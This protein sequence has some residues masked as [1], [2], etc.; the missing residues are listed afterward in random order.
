MS[1]F[2]V[3]PV[4]NSVNYMRI[5]ASKMGYEQC[6]D[7]HLLAIYDMEEKGKDGVLYCLCRVDTPCPC[8]ESVDE[9]E[10]NGQCHC[11]IFRRK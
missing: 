8:P 2:P 11:G 6:F 9:I 3:D 4:T 7:G 5:H 1:A 10:R